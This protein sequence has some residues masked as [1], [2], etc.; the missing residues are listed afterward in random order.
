MTKTHQ[1]SDDVTI[2]VC[3]VGDWREWRLFLALGHFSDS[4]DQVDFFVHPLVREHGDSF[5][6]ET[7]VRLDAQSF[8]LAAQ[9]SAEL[10]HLDCG[11]SNT[12]ERLF[13]LRQFIST[14]AQESVSWC[15]RWL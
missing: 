2:A 8:R 5:W 11:L 15:S 13:F 12:F 1:T 10:S 4:G 6:H 3:A 9:F 7:E 14:S